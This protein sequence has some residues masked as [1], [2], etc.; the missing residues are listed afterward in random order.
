MQQGNDYALLADRIGALRQDLATAGQRW[1][2]PPLLLAVTKTQPAERINLLE[3]LGICD[4]GENRVQDWL[5]KEHQISNKFQLHW[6]GRLQTNK[7]KYIIGR[8]CL[9]HSLDR[10]E[11][12]EEIGRLS[13]K[14]GRATPVLV[15]V[16]IA[17][18][19]QK[20][21]LPPEALLPFL[22]TYG[23]HPGLSIQGLMAIMP[24]ADDP[25]T[26]RPLFVQMRK[27]FE[28]TKEQM[29]P[30]IEMRHLS[31]GMSADC[32]VAAQEGATIVRVG[33]A[34]FG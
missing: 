34:L 30:G 32:I 11:L 21:G 19:P 12:A 23:Q 6:I 3:N 14:L 13:A 5:E 24:Q 1:G 25:E 27:L 33:S 16:N 7:V 4:I 20:G 17:G 26:L 18:E 29:L 9:I 2:A 15:Q 28:H 22:K 8:V 31:M 10:T